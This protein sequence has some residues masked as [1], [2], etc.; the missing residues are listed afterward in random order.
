[1]SNHRM[2]RVS[3]NTAMTALPTIVS[4]TRLPR[5][6]IKAHQEGE[7]AVHSGGKGSAWQRSSSIATTI[8]D[9]LMRALLI[10]QSKP[11]PAQHVA[12]L[13]PGTKR[14]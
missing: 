12:F 1:M 11:D 2:R 3:T 6:S 8:A 14:S 9:H 4:T 13:L 7:L 10:L 5:A